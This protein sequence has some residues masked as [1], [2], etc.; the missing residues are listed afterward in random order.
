[1]SASERPFLA[2]RQKLQLYSRRTIEEVEAIAE[3]ANAREA[4]GGTRAAVAP[5]YRGDRSLPLLQCGSNRKGGGGER[6]EGKEGTARRGKN[7]SELSCRSGTTRFLFGR[8]YLVAAKLNNRD[9]VRA[10]KRERM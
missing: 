8:A 2:N 5:F 4:S 6:E 10:R 1:M 7:D 9:T 3:T